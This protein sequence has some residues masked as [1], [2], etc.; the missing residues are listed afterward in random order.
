M[1]IEENDDLLLVYRSARWVAPV[2]T[3]ANLSALIHGLFMGQ[4]ENLC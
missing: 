4:V 3:C 2:C 1:S